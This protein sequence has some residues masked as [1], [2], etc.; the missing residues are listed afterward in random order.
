M[1]DGLVCGSATIP[2][3]STKKTNFRMRRIMEFM[4]TE[5]N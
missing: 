2:K 5:S 4:G 3:I 1:L